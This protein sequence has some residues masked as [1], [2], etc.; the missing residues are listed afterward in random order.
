MKSFCAECTDDGFYVKAESREEVADIIKM[1]AQS[2]HHM[3]VSETEALKI[4]ERC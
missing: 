2:K 1:H 3:K 4:I